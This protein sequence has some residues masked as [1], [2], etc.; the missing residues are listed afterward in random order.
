ME[1]KV[2]KVPGRRSSVRLRALAPS[3]WS[4]GMGE[5]DEEP[6][7]RGVGQQTGRRDFCASSPR[8]PCVDPLGKGMGRSATG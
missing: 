6:R 5:G 8:A 1:R 4:E 2:A 3:R 7:A